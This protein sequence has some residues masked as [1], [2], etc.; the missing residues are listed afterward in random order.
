[1]GSLTH[2]R[3]RTGTK[4]FKEPAGEISNLAVIGT[5]W[6]LPVPLYWSDTALNFPGRPPLE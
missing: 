6:R 3:A 5:A 1:M 4:G 2:Q